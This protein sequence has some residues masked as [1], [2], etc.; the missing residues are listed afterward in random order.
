MWGCHHL[1]S[2]WLE[3][4]PWRC[5]RLPVKIHTVAYLAAFTIRY[6]IWH[7]LDERSTLL[8]HWYKPLSSMTVEMKKDSPL[9]NP[10]GPTGPSVTASGSAGTSAGGCG[11]VGA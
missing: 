3:L 11:S 1:R 10:K 5:L 6:Y 8:S 2:V 4:E 7:A 9:N